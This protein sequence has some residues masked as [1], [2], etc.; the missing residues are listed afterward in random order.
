MRTHFRSLFTISTLLLVGCQT[1]TLPKAGQ[2]ASQA[3]QGRTLAEILGPKTESAELAVET[4]FGANQPE[5]ADVD[6][7]NTKAT[8]PSVAAD[9]AVSQQNSGLSIGLSPAPTEP[10]GREIEVSERSIAQSAEPS[11]DISVAVPGA[12]A[13]AGTAAVT[14]E[15]EPI[16][17][18]VQQDR[19][20]ETVEDATAEQTSE[21]VAPTISQ[22]LNWIPS[23]DETL[24][25]ME[26][27]LSNSATLDEKIDT[28]MTL[29]YL[30][31]AKLYISFRE[32]LDR[33]DT[34]EAELLMAEQREWL[35]ERKENLTRA[36]LEFQADKA[37]RY[38][39]AQAFLRNSHA[40]MREIDARLAALN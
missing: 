8:E 38:N 25:S 5:P 3:P 9:E 22:Q 2:P 19:P 32:L 28:L 29:A 7:A 10:S 11:S 34:T 35:Q 36:Y 30:V 15:A 31:D 21:A 16:A 37:G 23:L 33:V 27:Q 14:A 13:V 18:D 24:T 40:R 4:A 26:S 17:A 39:A 1:L 20:T 12:G 6:Q